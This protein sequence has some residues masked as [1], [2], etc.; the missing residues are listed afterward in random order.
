MFEKLKAYYARLGVG[1]KSK[2]ALWFRRKKPALSGRW[3]SGEHRESDG[4]LSYSPL[5]SSRRGYRLYS[6]VHDSSESL[7]LLVML[8]GCKQNPEAFAAGTRINQFADEQKFFVLYPEQG[9]MANPYRCWN[10]FDPSSQHGHGEAAIVAGMVRKISAS[11]HI[12]PTRVYVAGIS[13]GGAL[14]SALASCYA[15]LFAACAVHSGLMFQAASSPVAAISVM[16]HGSQRDPEEAGADAIEISGN[17]VAAMPVMV[18]HG[19]ADDTVHPVNGEQTVAQFLAMNRID[20][21]PRVEEKSHGKYRYEI[22][23]YG[24]EAAPILRYIKI[25]EMGHAWSGGN[26]RYPYNDANG[27]DA[28]AMMLKFFALHRRED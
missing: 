19:D 13:A 1:L 6:P 15:D 26:S 4:M 5:V 21:A 18:I 7:P 10:W 27:P 24:L 16:R 9:R 20:G 25:K 28:S 23:D 8:H 2:F 17:K 22:R 12:D 3:S 14:A 11:H